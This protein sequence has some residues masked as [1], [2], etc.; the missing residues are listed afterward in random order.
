MATLQVPH[1]GLSLLRKSDMNSQ[2]NAPTRSPQVMRLSLEPQDSKSLLQALQDKEKVRVRFGKNQSLN[3]GD[4]LI[5]LYAR[6]ETCR[7]ELYLANADNQDGIYFTGQVSHKL[8]TQEAQKVVDNA[9]LALAKLKKT[10]KEMSEAKASNESRIVDRPTLGHKR[11]LSNGS[12]HLSPLPTQRLMNNRPMSP[13]SSALGGFSGSSTPRQGPTSFS[14]GG[15]ILSEEDQL[16]LAAIKVPLI[17]M[18]AVEGQTVKELCKKIHCPKD[19]CKRLLQKYAEEVRTEPGKFELRDKMYKDLDVWKFSYPSQSIRQK[20]IERAITAFDRMRVTRKDEAWQILLPKEDRGKGVVLSRTNLQGT[21][22]T[23]PPKTTDS[24]SEAKSSS[25][26]ERGQHKVEPKKEGSKS[27]TQRPVDAKATATQSDEQRAKAKNKTSTT[28]VK[29]APKKAARPEN[30]KFK[31]SEFVEDSDDDSIVVEKP[32]KK[33]KT[34]V[35]PTK[36]AVKPSVKAPAAIATQKDRPQQTLPQPGRKELS[37]PPRPN[38]PRTDSSPRKRSPLASSPPTNATDN[39]SMNGTSTSSAITSPPSSQNPVQKP[40]PQPIATKADRPQANGMK[41]KADNQEEQR[42]PKRHQPSQTL[43]PERGR[44]QDRSIQRER[45]QTQE[46]NNSALVSSASSA[47][48]GSITSGSASP[49]DHE[50]LEQKAREFK[51]KYAKYHD[52]HHR[53]TK[54][55]M[56]ASLDDRQKLNRMHNRIKDLK[57]EIWK[58]HGQGVVAR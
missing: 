13:N 21:P 32:P 56:K 50:Q 8:E 51:A 15:T 47:S 16:K 33:T 12:S 14:L 3:F 26:S 2:P 24:D 36:N 17:H 18:L 37:L 48:N 43:A 20:V 34:E 9:D 25:A 4:K 45:I 57:Q 30:T 29:E 19:L 27:N 31:S 54:A 42:E 1:E 44:A 58:L 7:S 46:N 5:Q 10:M 22:R 52:L 23:L 35:N 38:R 28:K 39:D 41:R 53:V 11:I 49:P 40:A 55:G 6:P